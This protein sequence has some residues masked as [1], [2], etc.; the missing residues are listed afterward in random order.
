M[1][2]SVPKTW[3]TGELVTAALLNGH[4]RDQLDYLF[5]PPVDVINLNLGAD[6]TTTST[7]SFVDVDG[8]NLAQTIV[9]SGEDVRITFSGTFSH[10]T[11]GSRVYLRIEKDGVPMQAD[12]GLL[13]HTLITNG[14]R[15]H[16]SF[17]IIDESP[18]GGSHTYKLQ[19]KTS[20]ATVTLHAGAGGTSDVHGQ[21]AARAA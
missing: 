13:E 19:W 9:T 1:A 3:A 4:L 7:A 2:W 15:H 11:G 20:A 16:I 10:S 6:L 5:T 21:F 17:D 18:S 8:T 12:D 14:A